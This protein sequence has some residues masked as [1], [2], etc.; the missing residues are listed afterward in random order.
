[1]ARRH[2][3]GALRVHPHPVPGCPVSAHAGGPARA[4]HRRIGERAEAAW[5]APAGTIAAKLEAGYPF[6][7]VLGLILLA[8]A[9]LAQGQR[10]RAPET[11]DSVTRTGGERSALDWMLQMPL[12]H[13]W[14]EYLLTDWAFSR[15]RAEAEMLA[16]LAALSRERTWL[17]QARRTLAEVAL[18]EVPWALAEAEVS[19]AL[20][21]TGPDTLLAGCRMHLTAARVSDRL[22]R[23]SEARRHRARGRTILAALAQSLAEDGQLQL[24][25]LSSPRFHELQDPA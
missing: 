17:G 12:A 4:L 6:G 15:A 24:R 11:F 1:V 7:Q 13:S 2:G 16:S 18:A 3:G 20:A 23:A 8:A 10:Q 19:S 21:A 22:G 5:G 14:S 9:D 25:V